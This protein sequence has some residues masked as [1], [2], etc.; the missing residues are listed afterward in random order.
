MTTNTKT[1]DRGRGDSAT[2]AVERYRDRTL[3]DPLVLDWLGQVEAEVGEPIQVNLICLRECPWP[4]ADV[5]QKVAFRREDDPWLFRRAMDLWG[6][7]EFHCRR[8]PDWQTVGVGW[9]CQLG[10]GAAVRQ[11]IQTGYQVVTAHSATNQADTV[12][13]LVLM[14]PRG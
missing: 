1:G 10:R 3:R 4:E 2:D 9:D 8:A 12:Y 5:F 13:G 14:V 11:A 7:S 6:G